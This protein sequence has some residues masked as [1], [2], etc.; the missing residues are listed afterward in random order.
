MGVGVFAFGSSSF[1]ESPA[2]RD[3]LVT[4][5]VLFKGLDGVTIV[6][7]Q[8]PFIR[9]S[10]DG[11][12]ITVEALSVSQQPNLTY[13]LVTT[14]VPGTYKFSFLTSGM[15]PGLID[16]EFGGTVYDT[17]DSQLVPHNLS[18][19][20]QIAIGEISHIQDLINRVRI[21]LMDEH[22]EDYTLDDKVY[23]WTAESLYTAIREAL[24]LFNSAGP[25]ISFFGNFEVLP[26]STDAL[27]VMAAK[28][29]ALIARGRFEKAIA[30][31]YS[32]VHTLNI[33]RSETYIRL[34]QDLLKMA[35]EW[36]VSWKKAT[37]PTSIGLKSQRLPF[38]VN[39]VIG[40]LPNSSS[41][42]TG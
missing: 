33:D 10:R 21:G 5:T 6:D 20:G 29:F 35:L 42:F 13:P 25:Q 26:V 37:P 41:F 22:P 3:A 15:H 32:D 27:I 14:G 19:R 4:V 12:A 39:R 1:N 2:P 17:V 16:L 36:I 11:S 34:G 40:L 8:N 18:V 31:S 7:P 23:Q 28:G 30:M 38:R 24:D 9:L